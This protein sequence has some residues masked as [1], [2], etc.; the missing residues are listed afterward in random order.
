MAETEEEAKAKLSARIDIEI[1]KER[2][3]RLQM[4]PDDLKLD[5]LFWQENKDQMV[6]GAKSCL[7]ESYSIEQDEVFFGEIS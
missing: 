5:C 2:K 3:K 4:W 1:E 6:N 7:G